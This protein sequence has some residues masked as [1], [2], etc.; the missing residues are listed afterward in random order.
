[1]KYQFM[2]TGYQAGAR[3]QMRRALQSPQPAAC[4]EP[5]GP[6]WRG[7]IPKGAGTARQRCGCGCRSAEAESRREQRERRECGSGDL[8]RTDTCIPMSSAVS[9]TAAKR[10]KQPQCTSLG[11]ETNEPWSAST[12]QHF[13]DIIIIIIF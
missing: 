7:C 6:A 5:R 11:E 12:M 2:A 9:L 13:S 10:W 1:M 3:Q 4:G 8:P